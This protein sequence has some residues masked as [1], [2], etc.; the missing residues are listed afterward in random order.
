MRSDRV[1]ALVAHSATVSMTPRTELMT[2]HNRPIARTAAHAGFAL[3]AVA[4]FLD[5]SHA[6]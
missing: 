6:A 5:L 3:G 2:E 1:M 4:E